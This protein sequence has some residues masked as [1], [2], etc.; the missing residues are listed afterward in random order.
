MDHLLQRK[1]TGFSG[2]D[3]IGLKEIIRKNAM[4]GLPES[5][6]FQ[7]TCV[8]LLLFNAEDPHILAIQKTDSEGYPWRNQ[9]ALPGGHLEKEDA[10]PLAGAFRELEEETRISRDQVEF[11][12]S[13]G[14]YQTINGRDI[15][16]FIGVWDA[17]GPVRYDPSE[18]ARILNVPLRALVQTHRV[19]N[20]HNRRPSIDELRYPVEDVVIWGATA[21]ILHQL[22]E[23]LYPLLVITEL[24]N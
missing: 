18:I 12:G 2:F 9:V 13:L 8:F 17:T 22:I 16:A 7:P 6:P 1:T 5:N 20:F 11:I 19:G 24:E 14:H 3:V 15:E 10:S 4:P 23:L 21:R